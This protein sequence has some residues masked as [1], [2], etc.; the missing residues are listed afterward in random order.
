M[1]FQF[2]YWLL[3]YGVSVRIGKELVSPI[4]V[5]K[6]RKPN[7]FMSH[8]LVAAP[9]CFSKTLPPPPVILCKFVWVYFD[10][11]K[12]RIPCHSFP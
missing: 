5:L 4:G 8:L 1:V 7:G 12:L 3:A 2:H 10:I 11:L 6:A 9:Y